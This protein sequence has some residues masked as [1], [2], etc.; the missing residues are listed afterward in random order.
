MDFSFKELVGKIIKIYQDELT[1]FSKEISDH[2]I[3]LRQ[4]FI[5]CWKY[6]IS[7]N[8]AKSI[9]GVDEGNLLGH[10]ISKDGVKVDPERVEAIKK[11]HLPQNL[12]ALQSF[13]GQINFI[14]RFI[15][16]LAELMN[17]PQKLLKKDAKFE[18]MDEGK[19]AFKSIKDA[20]SRS[21]VLISPDYS[22]EFQIFSFSWEDTIVVFLFK[23]IRRENRNL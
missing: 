23:I 16:N 2:I 22:K 4:V 21:L 8:P 11:V 17:P 1:T 9:F 12:K 20:I 10:I 13:N 5:R 3:H 14:R 15:P 7:L 19:D 6:G 18:W